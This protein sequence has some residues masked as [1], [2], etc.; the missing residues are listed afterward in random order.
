MRRATLA[1][2]ATLAGVSKSAVSRVLSGT[3][4]TVRISDATMARIYEAARQLDYQPNAAARALGR[5]RTET[6][7]LVVPASSAEDHSDHRFSHLKLSELLSGID[8][9]TTERGFHLIVQIAG[10]DP[11]EDP[12]HAQIWKNG[13]VD[14]VLWLAMPL[15]PRLNQL[16]CPIVGINCAPDDR[17]EASTVNADHY[18][19]GRIAT[20]HLIRLGH[21][22]IAHISAP[23]SLWVGAERE[24]GYVDAM[25]S[26][27]YS[28]RI[29]EGDSFEES[30]VALARELMASSMP[31]TAIFCGGDLMAF[32]ALRAAQR[33]GVNVPD[34]LAL[35]GSD[36][37]KLCHFTTPSLSTVRMTMHRAA[38]EAAAILIDDIEGSATQPRH[39]VA[40][41]ELVIRES[42]GFHELPPGSLDELAVPSPDALDYES[43]TARGSSSAAMRSPAE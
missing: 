12:R 2:V 33:A 14:G 43:R 16:G 42:C 27:G 25:L 4:S 5:K 8:Q 13:A 40:P 36:G 29:L 37:M 38:A 6:I 30:G 17:V 34:D 21:T 1:D 22:S 31:P 9:I 41:I 35:I 7:A 19:A 11:F 23:R 20:E 10:G 18:E 39:L 26:A 32:G 24:R 15:D 3:P 28:P